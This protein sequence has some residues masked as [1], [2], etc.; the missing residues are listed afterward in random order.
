MGRMDG[1]KKRG[2]ENEEK[3]SGEWGEEGWGVG[4]I[5][6]LPKGLIV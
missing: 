6:L 2:G 5:L 4:S 3:G 1:E